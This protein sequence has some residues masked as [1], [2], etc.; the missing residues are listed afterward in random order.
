[1]DP[2][3]RILEQW[4]HERPDLQAAA[5]GT[6]GR[7][8]RLKRGMEKTWSAHGLNGASFDVLAFLRRAGTPHAL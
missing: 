6:A 3:D 1:M 2:I 8:K 4:R 5:I 7:I